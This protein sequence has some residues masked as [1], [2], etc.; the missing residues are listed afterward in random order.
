MEEMYDKNYVWVE[1]VEA[2]WKFKTPM[3]G[4]IFVRGRV[5][6]DSGHPV[7]RRQVELVPH[8]DTTSWANVSPAPAVPGSK[9]EA[10]GFKDFTIE[11]DIPWRGSSPA[12]GQP[13]SDVLVVF[14]YDGKG[15]KT[16]PVPCTATD[17]AVKDQ[18]AKKKDWDDYQDRV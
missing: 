2:T 1:A 12:E 10:C 14:S 5:W 16:G 3:A 4:H 11:R 9:L 17:V 6:N 8:G 15:F 7:L 18:G 13:I